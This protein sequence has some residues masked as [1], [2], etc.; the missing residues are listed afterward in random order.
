VPGFEPRTDRPAPSRRFER[1]TASVQVEPAIAIPNHPEPS[2]IVLRRSAISGERTE[3]A[4]RITAASSAA[5]WS[6][7]AR[8]DPASGRSM[9]RAP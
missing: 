9:D 8:G 2:R 1:C 3:S 4:S 5:Q 7:A 6:D